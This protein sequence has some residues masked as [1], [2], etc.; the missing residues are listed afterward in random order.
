MHTQFNSGARDLIFGVNFHLHV[1]SI[2]CKRAEMTGQ[3]EGMCRLIR[4][5]AGHLCDRYQ[6]TGSFIY[7]IG[8]IQKGQ[9]M[10]RLLTSH[11]IRQRFI[12]TKFL[13]VKLFS[14]PSVLTYVLGAQKNHLIEIVL[15][16]THNICFG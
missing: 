7:F 6:C 2:L 11:L 10:I 12:Y 9:I 14:N 3:T 4:T 15:L 5:F 13:S 16:S 1:I 8:D